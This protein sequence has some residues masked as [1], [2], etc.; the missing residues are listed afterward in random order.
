[1]KINE[2]FVA[3]NGESTFAGLRTVFIRTFGCSLRCDFCDTMYAVEGNEFVEM[4]IDEILEKIKPY[5]C[6]R[7]TITGGEPLQQSGAIELVK[8][9]VHEG[10]HVEIETNGAVPVD[11]VAFMPGVTLT[12][13]WKCPSSKM[14]K[15]MLES[16]LEMLSEDDVIK[17]VVGTDEDLE[18]VLKVYK[19]TAAQCY[20]SPVFGKIELPKMV[21]FI[22]DNKLDDVR[23]QLQQHKIIFDPNMRGV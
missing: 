22:L 16:N 2:I 3:L 9:L 13:D 10:Y 1:M 7:I 5:E 11:D 12:M 4:T 6:P 14:N 15:K 21:Q 18:E 8:K 19:K 17:F 23:M 20:I